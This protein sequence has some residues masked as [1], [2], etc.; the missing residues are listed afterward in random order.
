MLVE[1]GEPPRRTRGIPL[2]HPAHDALAVP[3]SAI[4]THEGQAFVFVQESPATY[5]RINVT[6][7]VKADGNVE[8]LTGLKEGA[9][10]VTGGAFQLKSE[11][12]IGQLAE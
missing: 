5:R 9:I 10:L 11:L 12:L 1:R 3:E 2:H 8:I 7:G 6:T 4:V